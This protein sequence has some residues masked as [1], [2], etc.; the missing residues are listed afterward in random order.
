MKTITTSNRRPLRRGFYVL[1]LCVA[2]LWTIARN[3]RA[4]LLY[5]GQLGQ[6]V[7]A[8]DAN[9]GAA[10][11]NFTPVE[12]PFPYPLAASGN[13]LFV[14]S[15]GSSTP[16]SIA[17]YSATT[18]NLIQPN[19]VTGVVSP[20]ALA[21]SG[22]TLYVASGGSSGLGNISAYNDTT[23]APD[24]NFT[25]ITGSLPAGFESFGLAVLGNDLFVANFSGSTV[26]EYNATTGALIKANFITGLSFVQSL[27]VSSNDVLVSD[28]VNRT[29]TA[30]NAST[31][32]PD[33]NFTTITGLNQPYGLAVL[34]NNLYVAVWPGGVNTGMVGEYNATTGAA[35]NANF[36][37]T[38]LDE[39][40]SLAVSTVPE[41]STWSMIA[42]GGVALLGMML[43]KK[44][45][46]VA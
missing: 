22:N 9:T 39:P 29:V 1:L 45:H 34:G 2:A 3:A 35:F 15:F 18:G 28:L 31:G 46:T 17:E 42:V 20:T 27:T 19:F 30:Y 14:G 38:G 44:H 12:I 4:Q 37:P 32:A 36:I 21:I 16:T 13:D 11:P 23:G 33:P 25:T 6:T 5:V 8:Y 7:S 41:P 43:R 26:S 40:V 24:P 10:D